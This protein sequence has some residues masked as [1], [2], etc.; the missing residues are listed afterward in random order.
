MVHQVRLTPIFGESGLG[1]RKRGFFTEGETTK[2]G[3]AEEK[4]YRAT[5][6]EAFRAWSK[7]GT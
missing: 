5:W 1:G 3:G 4:G 7:P 6:V 2:D